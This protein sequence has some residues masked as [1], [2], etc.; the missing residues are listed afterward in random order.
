MTQF[1]LTLCLIVHRIPLECIFWGR[2]QNQIPFPD[3]PGSLKEKKK[4][5]PSHSKKLIIISSSVV[6]GTGPGRLHGPRPIH[7]IHS[8]RTVPGLR[9]LSQHQALHL[10]RCHIKLRV[11]L[12]I[13]FR[14]LCRSRSD[15]GREE[16]EAA[17]WTLYILRADSTLNINSTIEKWQ[18]QSS[19]TEQLPAGET[20]SLTD[21]LAG[22]FLKLLVL[23]M[24]RSRV[25]P[26]THFNA[27]CFCTFSPSAF[28]FY[29]EIGSPTWKVGQVCSNV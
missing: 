25:R 19:M 6:L 22:L 4:K 29:S 9:A 23:V 16:D 20:F 18:H 26:T 7:Y 11:A 24:R 10:L 27:A 3:F 8:P 12:Q 15:G 14:K 13:H 2:G 17:G 28:Q 21:S 5:K 1:V